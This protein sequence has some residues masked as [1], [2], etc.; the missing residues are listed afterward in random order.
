M[1]PKGT[2]DFNAGETKT[3]QLL[4]YPKENFNDLAN[5]YVS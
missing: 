4:F 2:V 3:I 5:K 1:A